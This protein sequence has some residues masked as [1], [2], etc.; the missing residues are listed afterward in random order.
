[1]LVPLLCLSLFINVDVHTLLFGVIF[2]VVVVYVRKFCYLLWKVL[3]ELSWK[4]KRRNETKQKRPNAIRSI[5]NVFFT[6]RFHLNKNVEILQRIHGINS[7]F[8][9]IYP[10]R[11]KPLFKY[12][13]FF[14]S[15]WISLACLVSCNVVNFI[16]M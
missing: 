15:L 6:K 1:M 12:S 8:K 10:F 2:P 16:H 9:E 13:S 14:V 4:R 11:L 7:K 3:V 5:W